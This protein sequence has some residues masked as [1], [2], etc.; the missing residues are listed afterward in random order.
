APIVDLTPPGENATITAPTDIIGTV[1]DTNL[2]SYTL[3]LAPFGSDTF[4]DFFTGT[5]QGTN[6]VLG[7]LDPTMLQND[8]YVL[9]LSAVNTG[10]FISTVETTIN[11]A[12]NLK[13]GNFNLS[14]T[15]LS[16]RVSGS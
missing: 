6:A 1:S 15:D 2:V 12:Q 11:L 9:R 7:T 10:G 14:F 5:T 13:L 4:T 3:S 16:I 8:T